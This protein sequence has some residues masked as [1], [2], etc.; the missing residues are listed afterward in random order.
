MNDINKEFYLPSKFFTS[1]QAYHTYKNKFDS[2]LLLFNES[3]NLKDLISG[4]KISLDEI[5]ADMQVSCG[6]IFVRSQQ[7]II[8]ILR[9]CNEGNAEDAEILVRVLFEHYIQMKYIK[10]K[11][12]GALFLNYRWVAE[13]RYYDT[14][15]KYIPNDRI[16]SNNEFKE[17]RNSLNTK[18]DQFKQDY[19]NEKG[20]PRLHWYKGNLASIAKEVNENISYDMI[21]QISS[22]Y[23]HCDISGMRRFISGDGEQ[24]VFEAS[25]TT[26]D[27]GRILDSTSDIYGRIAI[28]FAATYKIEI[29]EAFRKYLKKSD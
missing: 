28:E 22:R 25:P 24:T 7:L 21:M 15:E 20:K 6:L 11:R 8:S 10:L 27:L 18:Y 12:N 14:L 2:V 17:F 5:E 13:K 29:P 23:I 4:S 3:E 16:F 9:L 1:N 26:K 19:I